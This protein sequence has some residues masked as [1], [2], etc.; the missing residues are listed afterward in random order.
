[1]VVGHQ[2]DVEVKERQGLQGVVVGLLFHPWASF[3]VVAVEGAP[4]SC[5]MLPDI[6]AGS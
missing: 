1:M 5:S 2:G 6:A 3:H 4:K